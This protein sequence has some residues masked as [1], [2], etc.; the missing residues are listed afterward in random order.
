MTNESEFNA[1]YANPKARKRTRI[2]ALVVG[3][4]FLGSIV[5]YFNLYATAE[6]R[7]SQACLEFLP[8][9]SVSE[10]TQVATSH[11]MNAP[12]PGAS[13]AYVVESK[14]FGRHGC[15]L[16]FTDGVLASSTYDF[17]G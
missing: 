13:I 10:A 15:K 5:Y 8:G 4:L 3:V 2:L 16:V 12:R 11:G 6:K 9:S 1:Y 7:V 17:Q 14:T